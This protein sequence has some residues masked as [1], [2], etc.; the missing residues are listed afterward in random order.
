[1]VASEFRIS[2]RPGMPV[3]PPQP[4]ELA[5]PSTE[6]EQCGEEAAPGAA[7]KPKRSYFRASRELRNWVED[8]VYTLLVGPWEFNVSRSLIFSMMSPR[9]ST[10]ISRR[11]MQF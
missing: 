6:P 8:L 4:D 1:M 9:P 7:E 2:D 11:T 10:F 5:D 3:V